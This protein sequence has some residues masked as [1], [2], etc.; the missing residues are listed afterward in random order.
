MATEK[1]GNYQIKVLVCGCIL[2]AL[3][4]L[5]SIATLSQ[6]SDAFWAKIYNTILCLYIN[7]NR[8]TMYN[9]SPSPLKMWILAQICFWVFNDKE[10]EFV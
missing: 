7:T 1:T 2:F 9:F 3:S 10:R 8:H 4:R 5:T 6:Y